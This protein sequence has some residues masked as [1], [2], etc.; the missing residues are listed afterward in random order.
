MRKIVVILGLLGIFLGQMDAQA[1][2]KLR[3][4]QGIASITENDTVTNTTYTNMVIDACICNDGTNEV[5]VDFFG[6]ATSSDI[7]ILA[8]E[9]LCFSNI[10]TYTVST[11]CSTGETAAIRIITLEEDQP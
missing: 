11:I 7:P 1:Y 4:R 2:D 3:N 8:G 9:K 5:F 10:G 6:T